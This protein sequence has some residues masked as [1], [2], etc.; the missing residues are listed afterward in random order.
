MTI[1]KIGQIQ[2]VQHGDEFINEEKKIMSELEKSINERIANKFENN[3]SSPE[4]KAIAEQLATE[5][6]LIMFYGKK[7][8]NVCVTGA[9]YAM[10]A[11]TAAVAAAT[12]GAVAQVASNNRGNIDGP[13]QTLSEENIKDLNVAAGATIQELLNYRELKV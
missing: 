5:Q 8:H 13:S 7:P 4:L 3:R 10:V 6:D 2:N 11:A 9:A 1:E 12:V